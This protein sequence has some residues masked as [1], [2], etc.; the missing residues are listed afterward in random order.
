MHRKEK[1]TW[2]KFQRAVLGTLAQLKCDHACPLFISGDLFDK[3]D[4][5]A[6]LINQTIACLPVCCG[7][8]GNHDL[9][10]HNYS[11]IDQS[12]YWTLVEA[13]RLNTLTPAGN[14]PQSVEQLLVTPFPCGFPPGPPT[15]KHSLALNVA[16]VHDY[17]WTEKTGHPNA[18]AVKRYGKQFAKVAEY[19][20]AFF[21]D[22][23][24]GFLIE[25]ENKVTICN[26][27][28]LIQRKSNEAKLRPF[29]ALLLSDGTVKRHYLELKAE[30]SDLGKE[31]DQI[32]S[33]LN[34][35]LTG[36]IEEMADTRRHGG[37][38]KSTVKFWCHEQKIKDSVKIIIMKAVEA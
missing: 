19:D 6:A 11:Q 34:A 22:N 30:W 1:D 16:I 32:Q 35:D 37:D 38:W 3:W 10:N 29:V 18:P 26:T 15:E 2:S 14:Q 5:S 25:K 12:A 33:T 13:G 7:I 31:V 9:P 21:G 23:H 36:F 28:C 20:V 17:I 8:P 27:G 24:H 4:S